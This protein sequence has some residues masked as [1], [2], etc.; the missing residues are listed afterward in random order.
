MKSKPATAAALLAA[1][2]LPLAASSQEAETVTVVVTGYGVDPAAAKKAAGR[3]A[4]EQVVGQLVDAETLVEN[5]ELVND[6][7]LTYSGA[8]LEDVDV[9]GAPSQ[10]DGLWTVKVRAAV[11][12][13]QLAQK[14]K[15]ENV[16]TVALKKGKLFEQAASRQQEAEDAAAIVK[17]AF[18][19]FPKNVVRFE[20]CRNDDGTPAVAVSDADGTVTVEAELG[21]DREAWK[22]W[23]RNLVSKLER[24]ARK[25]EDATWKIYQAELIERWVQHKAA[26]PDLPDI[27]SPGF[28][29]RDHER[30][31]W[32]WLEFSD[33]PDFGLRWR[34]HDESGTFRVAV[35]SS[36]RSGSSG[37]S[38]KEF[39]LAGNN[40][41]ALRGVFWK[42]F[43]HRLEL[44]VA[45][46]A[47]DEQ[48]D[49]RTFSFDAFPGVAL[50]DNFNVNSLEPKAG[51]SDYCI[52]PAFC[53]KSNRTG[54][55][56]FVTSGKVVLSL[57]KLPLDILADA[58]D[59]RTSVRFF[60]P[61]PETMY[62][63]GGKLVPLED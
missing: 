23:S 24:V 28:R 2:L 60:V 54:G 19:G 22:E 40:E 63:N 30:N 8:F 12:K 33:A 32:H 51:D 6:R 41:A 16:G 46:M 55:N 31:H 9:V 17:A 15:A 18:E 20:V 13:T 35:V 62:V 11:R 29:Q 38:A 53:K 50:Y 5:D 34:D 43:P 45:L 26:N 14:L 36:I 56:Y 3:A 49:S 52:L 25:T 37:F 27:P 47:D 10:A 44:T 7:I 4:I 59:I 48:L 39:V 61:G 57:G 21:I 1:F 58:T 42:A